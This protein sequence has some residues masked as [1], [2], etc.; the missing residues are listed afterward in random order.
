VSS[1][2]THRNPEDSE[3]PSASSEE[4]RL[5]VDQIEQLCWDCV[6][7]A[8]DGLGWPPSES[9]MCLIG[10]M[11]Y[12]GEAPEEPLAVEFRDLIQAVLST[13]QASETVS[14]RF[15]DSAVALA[16]A[17]YFTRHEIL[18]EYAEVAMCE[19]LLRQMPSYLLWSLED[20][21]RD[22]FRQGVL[23]RDWVPNAC[24]AAVSPNNQYEEVRNKYGFDQA[25]G[26]NR[27]EVY[28]P[29]TLGETGWSGEGDANP[30]T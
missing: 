2:Y 25:Y 11:V 7:W 3:F 9:M 18:P 20:G 4:I 26:H 13:I 16:R 15:R 30:D 14:V 23:A 19:F 21:F 1:N 24:G 5:R 10:S 27:P 22:L 17:R 29:G 28:E 6:M 12:S 8:R